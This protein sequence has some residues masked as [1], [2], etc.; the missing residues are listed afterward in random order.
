[1]SQLQRKVHGILSARAQLTSADMLSAMKA[2]K[3]VFPLEQ[4]TQANRRGLMDS[5]DV[6]EVDTYKQLL[7]SFGKVDEKLAHMEEGGSSVRTAN[8]VY[9]YSI[10]L[11]CV[12]DVRCE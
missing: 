1:M 8:I 4:N 7:R 9:M 11:C 6:R 5:L 12:C 3:Q 10:V 2:L